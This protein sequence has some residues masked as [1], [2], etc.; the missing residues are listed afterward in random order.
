LTKIQSLDGTVL[1]ANNSRVE[2]HAGTSC[3]QVRSFRFGSSQT[4]AIAMA[5]I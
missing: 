5:R 3:A 4:P 1:G 2:D